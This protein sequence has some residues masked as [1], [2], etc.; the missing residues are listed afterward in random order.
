MKATMINKTHI[1]GLVYEHALELKTLYT[2]LMLKEGFLGNASFFKYARDLGRPR[3]DLYEIGLWAD[4]I[5]ESGDDIMFAIHIPQESVTIPETLDG[6]SV[7]FKIHTGLEEWDDGKN[8][9]FLIFVNGEVR[10]GADINHREMKLFDKAVAGTQLTIDIQAYTGTLHRE[11]NF[12]AELYELDENV[13]QLYYDLQVPL[14]SFSRLDKDDKIR[15]D[16]Q[17]VLNDTI[18]L[19]DL[20]IPHSKAFKDSIKKAN[21]CGITMLCTGMRHFKH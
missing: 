2:V 5:V 12:L 14:W 6:K 4:S 17:T 13:N 16:M 20:R 21:E 9:Q 18:N 7:W 11:F 15:L 3:G 10:Q 8:P 19:L 1:E